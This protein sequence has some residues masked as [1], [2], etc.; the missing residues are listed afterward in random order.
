MNS[1]FFLFPKIKLAHN[2]IVGSDFE[3]FAVLTNHCMETKTCS[4][5][6]FARTISYNGKL[7]DSC[8]F[9]S[10][11]VEVAPGEGRRTNTDIC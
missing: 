2:M 8:G 3:V 1:L 5:M 11:K 7:G 4:F 10:E 9:I 6:F